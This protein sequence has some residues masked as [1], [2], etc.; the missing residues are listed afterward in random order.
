MKIIYRK[1]DRLIAGY[2]FPRRDERADN[3][4]LSVE[5]EN[6]LKSELG[7]KAADYGF[8]NSA[9]DIFRTDSVIE[10]DEDLNVTFKESPNSIAR[11]SATDKL[12]ALGLTDA[13]IAAIS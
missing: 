10:L 7:G 9:D 11:K 4:A 6:I 8:I 13:E 2:V 5:L 3:I 12:K 1:S